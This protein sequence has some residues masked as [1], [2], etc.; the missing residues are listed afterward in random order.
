MTNPW[1]KDK[2]HKKLKR[3]QYLKELTRCRASSASCRTG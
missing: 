1:P 3:K 2:K